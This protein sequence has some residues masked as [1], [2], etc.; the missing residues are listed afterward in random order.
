MA[1]IIKP[2]GRTRGTDPRRQVSTLLN[3]DESQQKRGSSRE[4]DRSRLL[5]ASKANNR[6]TDNVYYLILQTAV[7][8]HV[9]QRPSVAAWR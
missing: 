4:V 8:K 2:G 1:S 3:V 5:L 6:E 7:G 9:M